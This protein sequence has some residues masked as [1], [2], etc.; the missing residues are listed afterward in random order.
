M[1][2]LILHLG[3]H[4]TGSSAV[5][6][7]LTQNV[8]ALRTAGIAFPEKLVGKGGNGGRLARAL[9]RTMD[10]P[11]EVPAA[12][13]AR[14]LAFCK[15]NAG[16]D[17]LFSAER[18]ESDLVPTATLDPEDGAGG[19]PTT[20]PKRLSTVRERLGHI[21]SLAQEA[22][23][24]G[25][26]LVYLIRNV[27]D[28]TNSGF[29]QQAKVISQGDLDEMSFHPSAISYRDYAACNRLAEEY[30]F[31]VAMDAVDPTAISVVDQV[32][33]LAGLSERVKAVADVTTQRANE[34]IG[35]LGV[36]A[37]IH[38][39]QV[40][41]RGPEDGRIRHKRAFSHALRQSCMGVPDAPFSGFAP[42]EAAVVARAD[43][44]LNEALSPWMSAERIAM[45]AQPRRSAPRSPFSI[46][47]LDEDQARTVR[48]ILRRVADIMCS[49]ENAAFGYLRDDI[50]AIG[51]LPPV[52]ASARHV[53]L[54][55]KAREKR[56]GKR[57]G[58]AGAVPGS[59][60]AAKQERRNARRSSRQAERKQAGQAVADRTSSDR[61]N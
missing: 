51:T 33:G 29:A 40:L 52:P 1:G 12:L 4:K 11:A 15:K 17:V 59:A 14:L 26:R 49:G 44:V 22:G 8:D 2:K 36:L 5:Q 6:L 37:G 21:N 10:G 30:G 25:V 3:C 18:F 60:E 27:V 55:G 38:L 47:D 20:S 61:G 35:Q 54:T 31:E 58:T 46:E 53:V 50:V 7:W 39:G 48:D 41:A 34:S 19:R 57:A 56:T 16:C 43:A 13:L 23:L 24:S 28:R 32:M 45:V 42:E 9:T